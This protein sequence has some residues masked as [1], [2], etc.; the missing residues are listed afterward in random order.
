MNFEMEP[1]D[2]CDENVQDLLRQT[3]IHYRPDR[4]EL[5]NPVR[6]NVRYNPVE[7]TYPIFGAMYVPQP[8]SFG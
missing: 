1:L 4:V 5:L 2:H 3:I 8:A 6:V 7:S